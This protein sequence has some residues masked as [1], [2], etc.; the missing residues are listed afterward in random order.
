MDGI[1][2]A[3]PDRERARSLLET[4][5]IR[6]DSIGLMKSNN[7]SKFAS[8]IIEEYYE[9]LLELITAILSMDGYKQEQMLP[10]AIWLS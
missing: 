4:V 6:L 5:S 7:I 10:E 1:I 9:V 8:K 3:T 2:K